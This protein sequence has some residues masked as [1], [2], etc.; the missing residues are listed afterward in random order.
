MDGGSLLAAVE[1]EHLGRPA[2]RGQQDKLLPQPLQRAHQGTGQRRLA[3]A[4]R[5]AQNHHR[6]PFTVGQELG[7][8]LR[9]G[10]LFGR[11]HMAQLQFHLH[12]KL[13]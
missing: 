9:G 7:E 13:L 1:R 4:R 6:Q 2:R 10:V 8:A 5:T 3:R 11:R 12:H